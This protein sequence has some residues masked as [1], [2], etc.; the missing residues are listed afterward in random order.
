MQKVK[1]CH[2]SSAHS[3][4]DDRIFFKECSSLAQQFDVHVIAIGEKDEVLNN[5]QIHALPKSSYKLKF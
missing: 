2:V 1:V 4:Y 3:V 5:V